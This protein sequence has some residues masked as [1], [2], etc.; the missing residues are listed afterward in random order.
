MYSSPS[1]LFFPPY[2][3]LFII[4]HTEPHPHLFFCIDHPYNSTPILESHP[5]TQSDSNHYTITLTSRKSPRI[6]MY[7]PFNFY[8]RF[9]SLNFESH[10]LDTKHPLQPLLP[11]I[12]TQHTIPTMVTWG[13]GDLL[14]MKEAFMFRIC[15]G[16][17]MRQEFL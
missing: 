14:L 11:S 3:Q 4:T 2:L 15:L 13:Y 16:Y 1:P 8:F 17:K 5:F 10:Q 9:V 12:C 6:F 7:T